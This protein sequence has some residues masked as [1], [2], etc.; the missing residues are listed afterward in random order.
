MRFEMANLYDF[1]AQTIDGAERPLRDYA[2][3]VVLVVNV[4]SQCG[5]TPHYAGLEELYE[6]Y[7]DRGL[8]VL[9]FPCNQFG[10][11]EP[12][13]E[14]EIKKFCETKFGVTFP[15]FAKIDV[16]GAN[17]HPLY[18]FLTEQP[19][20]PDGP[21]DIPWNFAKFLIDRSGQVAARF[22]PKTAPAS[23]EIVGSIEKA[24]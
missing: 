5:L 13:T 23:E 24:L 10:S 22:H 9:G 4:A 21:G 19:T 6:S 11:Q 3:K 8:V 14:T 7:Q 1:T 16:N 12:G 20:K 15:M 17:R 2:G 18:A